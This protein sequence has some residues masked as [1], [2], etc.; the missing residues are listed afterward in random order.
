MTTLGIYGPAAPDRSGVVRYID[1]S[2]PRLRTRFDCVRVSNHDYVEPYEFDHVLYHLGNNRHHEAAFRALR[3][4]P[5]TVVL[6]E[7]N[8]LDFYYSTWPWLPPGERAWLLDRLRGATGRDLTG[9]PLDLG[10]P[11]TTFD[12]YSVDAGCERLAIDQATNV[13][14]HSVAVRDE[15]RRRYPHA[16]IDHV[17]FP[18]EVPARTAGRQAV[19]LSDK[20]FVCASFGYIGEYKRIEQ[21][22]AAWVSWTDRPANTVLLLVGEKQYDVAVPADPSIR[23]LGYVDDE[24]YTTLLISVDVA[25]QLR[26]PH[27]GETSAVVRDLYGLGARLILTDIPAMREFTGAGIAHI[28]VGPHEVDDLRTAMAAL[29]RE[30]L[31]RMPRATATWTDWLTVIECAVAADEPSPMGRAR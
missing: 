15:L 14:V 27:L 4:R 31:P 22:L 3:E 7:F 1:E 17:P 25:V 19:G 21:V 9:N 13:L 28:A 26:F 12:W 20:Q 29:C 2:L 16:L 18:T 5:G 23:H 10:E 11:I 30:R 8:N 6:H 24:A